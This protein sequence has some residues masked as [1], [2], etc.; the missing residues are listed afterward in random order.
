MYTNDENSD[1]VISGIVLGGI[2]VLVLPIVLAT[3]VVAHNWQNTTTD[4]EYELGI[5]AD[6]DTPVVGTETEFHVRIQN[7]TAA[8]ASTRHAGEIVNETVTIT[9]T[10][11]N[12][13]HDRLTATIPENN[14]QFAFSYRFPTSGT[15]EIAVTA[16]IDGEQVTFQIERRVGNTTTASRNTP[17]TEPRTN[18][19]SLRRKLTTIQLLSGMSV[20]FALGAFGAAVLA[21]RG[22][23]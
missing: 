16:T 17:L 19:G 14:S 7:T 4:G 20:V 9:I 8:K 3:P 22:T 2:V 11:P 15:Y 6:P 10:D 12:G 5:D 23:D 21:Y 18:S 1:L 13:G